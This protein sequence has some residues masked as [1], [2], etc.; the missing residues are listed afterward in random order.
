MAWRKSLNTGWRKLQE[1]NVTIWNSVPAMMQLLINY[2]SISERGP[3][4]I[5]SLKS[6]RCILLS[7]DWFSTS[8]AKKILSLFNNKVT[9]LSLGGAT[10]ASIWSNSYLVCESSL[11]SNNILYGKPLPNQK[12]YILDKNLRPLPVGVPGELF[13]G[14]LGVARGYLNR[15]QLTKE[16]FIDNPFVINKNKARPQRE[17]LYRTGDLCQYRSDGNVIFLGRND[18]QVKIRGFR[19]ELGEIEASLLKHQA[20][21]EVTVLAQEDNRLVAYYIPKTGE[22]PPTTSDLRNYLSKILPDYM[23]PSAF[24]ELAAF[25]LTPNGKLDRKAL[26]TPEKLLAQES[27][28]APRNLLE[29]EM[30]TIWQ[31]VLQQEK[32]SVMANFFELGG[33]SL[34]AIQLV[35]NIKNT[36]ELNITILDLFKHPTIADL[37]QAF[38]SPN[39]MP[40]ITMDVQTPVADMPTNG[41]TPSVHLHFETQL[42]LPL[43][44]TGELKPV[45]AAALSYIPDEF[46]AQS[47]LSPEVFIQRWLA[48]APLLTG[49][50]ETFLGR[51]A[52]IMLPILASELYAKKALLN[53]MLAQSLRTCAEHWRGYDISHRA[54]SFGT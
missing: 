8:L 3:H 5:H 51:I 35:S 21:K 47:G 39:I 40:E 54:Y 18:F 36:L 9:L 19:V 15:E 26:P 38:S 29:Q 6:L 30:A 52:F 20:I 44:E 41:Q 4:H 46:I 25:P 17:R 27:Y 42:L 53:T 49:I 28:V 43:I 12:F 34:L 2:I 24:I 33:H 32:V 13:I 37:A 1:H 11:P 16:R 23:I 22:L 48:N 14:G 7:G 31:E 45:N 50:A 10:E